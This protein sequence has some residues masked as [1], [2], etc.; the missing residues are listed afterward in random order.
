MSVPSPS[1]LNGPVLSVPSLDELERVTSVP[2]E[3]VVLR[4]VDWTFYEQLVDSIPE[5][6]HIHLDYD[7]KDLELMS[8]RILA[9][10]RRAARHRAAG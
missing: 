5:W 9:V 6:S 3:R 8:H 1:P 10:R 2:D 4:D 7:G